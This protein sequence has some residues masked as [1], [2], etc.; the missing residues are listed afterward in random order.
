MSVIFD[1]GEVVLVLVLAW[2]KSCWL[3]VGDDRCQQKTENDEE[4]SVGEG[5][6]WCYL[7]VVTWWRSVCHQLRSSSGEKIENLGMEVKLWR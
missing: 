3:K 1:N 6:G 4:F 7:C 2:L 5:S